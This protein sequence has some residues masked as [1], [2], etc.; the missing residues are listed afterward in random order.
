MSFRYPIKYNKPVFTFTTIYKKKKHGKKPKVEI[1]VDGPFYT[2]RNLPAKDAQI[3]LR[4]VVYNKLKERAELSNC[5]F[6]KYVKRS[7]ND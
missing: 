1:F 6:V 3:A 2:N 7:E 4:D 5:E